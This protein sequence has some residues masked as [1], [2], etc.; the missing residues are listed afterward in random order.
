MHCYLWFWPDYFTL[1][2]KGYKLAVPLVPIGTFWTNIFFDQINV[3][4]LGRC[5]SHPSLSTVTDALNLLFNLLS[6]LCLPP[7]D[8]PS[9]LLLLKPFLLYGPA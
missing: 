2:L 8:A 5:P 6:S 1:F 4:T 9:L 7:P 3:L